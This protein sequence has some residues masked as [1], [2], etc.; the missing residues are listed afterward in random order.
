MNLDQATEILTIEI[1][2]LTGD[3]A[4]AAAF[5]LHHVRS[6]D[7]AQSMSDDRNRMQQ[8]SWQAAEKL[9]TEQLEQTQDA[10]GKMRVDR[11]AWKARALKAGWKP[12]T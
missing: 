10:L 2:K 7:M 8:E 5:L 11:D 9:L 12:A 3:T 6:L 1:P 4:Q